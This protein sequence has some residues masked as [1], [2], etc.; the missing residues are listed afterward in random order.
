[1]SLFEVRRCKLSSLFCMVKVIRQ[2]PIVHIQYYRL[3]SY[4]VYY[5]LYPPHPLVLEFGPQ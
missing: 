5:F 1:M 4:P 2:K 3:L